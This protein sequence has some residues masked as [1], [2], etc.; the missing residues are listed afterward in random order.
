LTPTLLEGEPDDLSA[1]VA[2]TVALGVPALLGGVNVTV[3]E[4]VEPVLAVVEARVPA[5]VLR[6][7]GTP[8]WLDPIVAV[9]V[10]GDD[11]AMKLVSDAVIDT[12]TGLA[13]EYRVK[14]GPG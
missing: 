6:V 13:I 10:I 3:I 7:I 14:V 1:T 8:A 11:P 9:T 4:P 2:V 12:D 5:V